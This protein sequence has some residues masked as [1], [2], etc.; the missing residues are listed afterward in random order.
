MQT[1][2][3]I[4]PARHRPRGPRPRS[5]GARRGSAARAPTDPTPSAGPPPASTTAIN[6]KDRVLD[7]FIEI[8]DPRQHR[9]EVRELNPGLDHDWEVLKAAQ[10]AMSDRRFVVRVEVVS[11]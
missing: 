10:L 5:G 2:A 3:G 11:P 9:P 8:C 1:R 7:A 6:G 4:A